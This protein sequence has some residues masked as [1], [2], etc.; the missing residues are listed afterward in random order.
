MLVVSVL[1]VGTVAALMLSV[2]VAVALLK[3][4]IVPELLRL[5]MPAA[6]LVMPAIVPVP[7][8]LI[9]PVLVKLA[10]AVVM[11]PEPVTKIIPAL[12]RVA[13]EQAPL[14]LS[15]LFAKLVNPPVP[16]RVP[17]ILIVVDPDSVSAPPVLIV[18]FEPN[19][20]AAGAVSV[21]TPP[22]L[23]VTAQLKF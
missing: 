16:D 1:I 17:A 18:R 10:R 14:M 9:V 19:E 8:R 5:T 12:V 2:L 22:L 7:P 23:I 13:I 4:V 15:V 11:L 20:S 3:E 6:L 21:M